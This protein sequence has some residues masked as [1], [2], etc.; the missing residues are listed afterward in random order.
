MANRPTSRAALLATA[1]LAPQAVPADEGPATSYAKLMACAMGIHAVCPPPPVDPAALDPD[2]SFM[3]TCHEPIGAGWLERVPVAGSL[4]EADPWL[5][6]GAT[7]YVPIEAWTESPGAPV[8]EH[9]GAFV[10][11][12]AEDGFVLVLEA[13]WGPAHRALEVDLQL[14]REGRTR[15]RIRRT[16]LLRMAPGAEHGYGAELPL[17]DEHGWPSP[18]FAAVFTPPGGRLARVVDAHAEWLDCDPLDP[19]DYQAAWVAFLDESTRYCLER[20]PPG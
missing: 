16:R 12:H 1:L 19:A 4:D 10:E 7:R 20:R 17:I 3:L 8:V 15:A 6:Y 2:R 5:A 13:G 11:A 9:V 14:D 18:A